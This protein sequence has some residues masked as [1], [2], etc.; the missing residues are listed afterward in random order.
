MGDRK[1]LIVLM[2]KATSQGWQITRTGG[3]HLKWVSPEGKMVFSGFSHSDSRS[4]K[5]LKN[6]LR[7]A[8]F[9]EVKTKKSKKR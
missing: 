8:G 3:G 6:Q 5:N 9:I 4:I 7:V 2:Q 1:D